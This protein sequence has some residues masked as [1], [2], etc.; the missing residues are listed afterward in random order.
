METEFIE[1]LFDKVFEPLISTGNPNESNSNSVA[2]P[3]LTTLSLSRLSRTHSHKNELPPSQIRKLELLLQH[4]TSREEASSLL[5]EFPVL[6]K[7]DK[8]VH[9]HNDTTTNKRRRLCV[10]STE[11]TTSTVIPS[12][13]QLPR[14]FVPFDASDRWKCMQ[15]YYAN[16]KMKAWDD[17]AI[18]R[19]VGISPYPVF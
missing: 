16:Q 11:P 5:L 15:R 4:D 17:G 3:I 10:E 12:P 18:P 7:R 9:T 14:L 6:C 19:L 2:V 8:Q 13:Q 1:E